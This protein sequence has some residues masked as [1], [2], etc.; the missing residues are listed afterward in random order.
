MVVR[1]IQGNGLIRNT[2]SRKPCVSQVAQE[3]DGTL[4]HSHKRRLALW[5]E[6]IM[7]QFSWSMATV[8]LPITSTSE[9]VRFATS[10]PWEM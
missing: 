4:I 1:E 8:G 2:A 3:S 6:Q 7:E 5:A 10:R 9:P